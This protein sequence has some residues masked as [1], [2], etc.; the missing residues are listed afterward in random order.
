MVKKHSDSMVLAQL[1]SFSF[2]GLG[3]T[4]AFQFEVVQ[5][6]TFARE[7][8]AFWYSLYDR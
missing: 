3:A 8:C 1:L 7:A 4:G 5:V 2:T 6:V